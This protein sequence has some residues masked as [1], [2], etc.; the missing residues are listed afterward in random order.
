MYK[1]NK[2]RQNCLWKLQNKG[3]LMLIHK[4]WQQTKFGLFSPPLS[5]FYDP[6]TNVTKSL[7]PPPCLCD[8]IYDSSLKEVVAYFPSCP[9]LI[10]GLLCSWSLFIFQLLYGTVAEVCTEET[11]PIMSGGPKYEYLWQNGTDFKVI[12]IFL[13]CCETSSKS[14]NLTRILKASAICSLQRSLFYNVC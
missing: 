7:P 10:L 2:L 1:V 9:Y 12:L 11:C 5:Y 6:C 8:V 13:F 4:K 3:S 14:Q